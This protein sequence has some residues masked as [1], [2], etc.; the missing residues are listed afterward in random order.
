M[1]RMEKS[2]QSANAPASKHFVTKGEEAFDKLVYDH[3]GYKLNVASSIGMVYAAER[4]GWGRKVLQTCADWI[5]KQGKFNAKSVH[6]FLTK[7]MFLTGGFL[8]MAPMKWYEDKKAEWVHKKNQEIYGPAA[9][10]PEIVTSEKEL[11][12]APKQGWASLFS[13]RA[14]ALAGF[15]TLMGI[16]WDNKSRIS[17]WTNQAFK[18]MDKKALDGWEEKNLSE[19][20]KTASK[21]FY[22]DRAVVAASRFLGKGWS[23][24]T[25]N[26]AAVAKTEEMITTFPGMMKQGDITNAARDTTASSLAYYTISELITSKFVAVWVY[27]LSRITAPFFDAKPK[28]DAPVA[29]FAPK[30]EGARNEHPPRTQTVVQAPQ[31]EG[32]L[33]EPVLQH[34]V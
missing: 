22:I 19:F 9:D 32:K 27:I 13:A 26:T 18:G 31:H 10:D 11:A 25:G 29:A 5:A 33:K 1:A 30:E 3:I 6:Y 21:G 17:R 34:A 23:K 15:Y 14:I 7:T 20:A 2:D 16:F 24:I 4:T 12:H 8:V 28:P